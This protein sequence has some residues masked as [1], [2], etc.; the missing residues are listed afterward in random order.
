M[1]RQISSC[2]VHKFSKLKI[3]FNQNQSTPANFNW[4]PAGL[5]KLCKKLLILKYSLSK[6]VLANQ[7][8]MMGRKQRFV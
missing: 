7:K 1:K 4:F 6:H 8:S 3:L 2:T 5:I